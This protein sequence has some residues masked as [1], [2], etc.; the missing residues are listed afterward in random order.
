M[1]KSQSPS[2]FWQPDAMKKRF[3]ISTI[4]AECSVDS[5][6]IHGTCLEC[7]GTGGLPPSPQKEPWLL[8]HEQFQIC[9]SACG[10]GSSESVQEMAT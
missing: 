10:V 5:Q 7:E 3:V 1:L 9:K 6:L 8:W 2:S 4:H